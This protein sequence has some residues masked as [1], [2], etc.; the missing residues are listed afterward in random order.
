MKNI[1][2]AA[3]S[4]VKLRTSNSLRRLLKKCSI[5][6]KQHATI[7]NRPKYKSVRA[8]LKMHKSPCTLKRN[9]KNKRITSFTKMYITKNRIKDI[10]NTL[11]R[12]KLTLLARNLIEKKHSRNEHIL[13]YATDIDKSGCDHTLDKRGIYFMEENKDALKNEDIDREESKGSREDCSCGTVIEYECENDYALI[14]NSLNETFLF[15]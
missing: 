8:P 3:K 4:A 14:C 13:T 12:K 10:N 11:R 5:N 2:K 6:A 15:N 1:R 7:Q 9:P